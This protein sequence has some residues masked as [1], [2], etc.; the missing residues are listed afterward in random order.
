MTTRIPSQKIWNFIG[1]YDQLTFRHLYLRSNFY[2]CLQP[3]NINVKIIPTESRNNKLNEKNELMWAEMWANICDQN[4][5]GQRIDNFFSS[6]VC[7]L[8]FSFFYLLPLPASF[9]HVK[10]QPTIPLIFSSSKTHSTEEKH[11]STH[12]SLSLR[13]S[14]TCCILFFCSLW[15]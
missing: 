8:I 11:S 1:R 2:P 12:Y 15:V 14:Q 13:T 9:A 7:F 4:K 3:A 5:R 10:Q 6:A